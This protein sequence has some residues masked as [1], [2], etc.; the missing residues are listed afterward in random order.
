[1]STPNKYSPEVNVQLPRC[2]HCSAALEAMCSYQWEMQ[3]SI[4]ISFMLCMYCPNPECRKI[5][6][7]QILVVPHA[8]EQSPIVGPH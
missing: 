5:L 6:G 4:G 7:T 2:P 1:M 8:R 3:I